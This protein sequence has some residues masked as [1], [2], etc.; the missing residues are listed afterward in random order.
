MIKPICCRC[1]KEL[2]EFG[3]ILLSPPKDDMVKKY[4]ICVEC[5]IKI[6]GG[7]GDGEEVRKNNSR[8]DTEII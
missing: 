5:F 2:K 7:V 6:L 1:G 4:H 3:A 8:F